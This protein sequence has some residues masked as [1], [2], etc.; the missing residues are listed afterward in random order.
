[1]KKLLIIGFVLLFLALNVKAQQTEDDVSVGG[2][3]KT[4]GIYKGNIAKNVKPIKG[5]IVIT[6]TVVNVSWCEE[7][8]LTIL[9]K[10]SDGK[11]VTVGTKDN[12]FS[13]P[14][15]IA[16]KKIMI[17]GMEA[18]KAGI[19][20]NQVNRALQKDIQIAATG[21]KIFE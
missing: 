16:G 8:C 2:T 12:N 17:E 6:G 21:L 18:T 7:D 11:L 3:S 19:T 5:Q 14:K 20:K 13:V 9:V 4:F 15:N 1:M 10:T